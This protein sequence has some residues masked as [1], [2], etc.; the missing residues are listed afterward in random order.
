MYEAN[1]FQIEVDAEHIIS[2]A[3]QNPLDAFSVSSLLHKSIRSEPYF[4]FGVSCPFVSDII[5]VLTFSGILQ[6]RIFILFPVIWIW[7]LDMNPL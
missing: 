4:L 1:I 5:S 6:W 2:I 3:S 7:I